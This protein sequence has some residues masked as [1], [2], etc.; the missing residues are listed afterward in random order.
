MAG[1]TY[2]MSDQLAIPRLS[3]TGITV[4]RATRTSIVTLSASDIILGVKIPSGVFII[5]GYISGTVDNTA[6]VFKVGVQGL[7]DNNLGT[8]LTLST[9][10]GLKRFDGASLP[11][12][13]S[14]SDD[15]VLQYSYV[16]LTVN[17]SASL[18]QSSSINLVVEYARKGAI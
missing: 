13:L 11:V 8:L 17:S 4:A 1:T 18:T 3:E 2:T 15:N 6:T 12:Q 14:M 10:A 16:T 5:D 9:T 7:T